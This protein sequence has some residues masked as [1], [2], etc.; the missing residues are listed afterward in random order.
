MNRIVIATGGSG[1]H[2]FPALK[3][4]KE[5]AARDHEVV[6]IGRS[7][8]LKATIEAVHL[9]FLRQYLNVLISNLTIIC[10]SF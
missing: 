10:F 9:V 5:L 7:D 2:I 6:F 4:A 8:L 3:V 1:G